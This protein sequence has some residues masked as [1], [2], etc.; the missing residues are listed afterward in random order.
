MKKLVGVIL[1]IVSVS[2]SF[3]QEVLSP[4]LQDVRSGSG[5]T[6]FRASEMYI[7][8]PDTVSVPFIDDFSTD[9][10]KRYDANPGDPNVTSLVQ[11]L[12]FDFPNV[13][14]LD[15]GTC[16]MT[17]TSYFVTYD[18]VTVDSLSVTYIP[19][20]HQQ[21]TVYDLSTYPFNST[22]VTVWPSY[23]VQLTTWNGQQDTLNYPNPHLCQDSLTVYFVAPAE[24]KSRW[25]DSYA[26]RNDRYAINPPTIGVAT[27]DGLNEM[28]FPYEFNPFGTFGS[29]DRLTSKPIYLGNALDS[30]YLSF[31]YQPQGLGNQPEP[32]DSLVLEFW[33]PDSSKWYHIWSTPGKAN[34]DF[35]RVHV[36]I[37]QP[38]FLKNGFQFRFRNYA[39]LNGALDHWH[40]DYV[41][42]N[43]LRTYIDTLMRDFAFRYPSFGLLNT[44]TAMPWK[45]YQANPSAYMRSDVSIPA[46]NGS[47]DPKFIGPGRMEIYF[48]GVQ[49]HSFP[50]T[51]TTPNVGG[52]SAFD[53]LYQVNSAPSN[54]QFDATVN[55]TCATFEVVQALST[56][57]LPELLTSNDTVRYTQHFSNYYAYDDGS[58]EAAY[59]LVGAGA[60]LAYKFTIPGTDTLR[61]LLI[62]FA[63]TVQDASLRTFWP[64]VWADNAGK[65]GAIIHQSSELPFHRPIYLDGHNTYVEYFFDDAFPLVS[66][67]FYVGWQQQDAGVLNIGFDR[68]RINNDKIFFKTGANWIASSQ[69]G[70]LM[71]RPVLKSAKDGLLN[72]SD[73]HESPN[74]L[75]F[76]NPANESIRI[77]GAEITH[78]GM[79]DLAGRAVSQMVQQAGNQVY[80]ISV[81]PAGV[82][83]FTVSLRNGGRQTLRFVKQ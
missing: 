46:Y 63:P 32:E 67:T 61:S 28:G 56:T 57:T 29:A 26:Y 59:G 38:Q 12:L 33:A 13:S 78:W 76:P 71:M 45:H 19:L 14:P 37:T 17:D 82:Y 25:I 39:T 35:K 79:T 44:Y 8:I 40:V 23:T 83:L 75:L 55:D 2:L 1:L 66:G 31:Q 60:Q 52:L 3:G 18:S 68:N 16:F 6:I 7:Y 47:A 24:T 49:T 69:E 22:T 74:L 51:I 48:D 20:P 70:S 77:E 54:F 50:Y 72:V 80:D 30:L 41:Y 62:H 11:Q 10:F 9:L 15:T 27:L 21:I 53:M 81:L 36:K 34:H 5:K 42:M 64:T 4:L 73:E 58:A 43:H 65:P